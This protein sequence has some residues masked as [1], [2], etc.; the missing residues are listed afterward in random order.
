MENIVNQPIKTKRELALERMQTRY[1]DKDFSDDEALYGQIVE[2]FAY[3]DDEIAKYKERE[4]AFSDMFTADPRSAHFLTAW[5]K[6]EDP[7]VMLVRM[8]GTEIK[9][10][11]DDPDMLDQIS[12]AQKEYLE[13]VAKNK[14]YEAT[15]EG[16]M[17]E[18]LK[19]IEAVQTEMGLTDEKI[20]EA[21]AL[22]QGVVADGTL[23]KYSAESIK[24][25]LKALSHD[26][27]VAQAEHVGEVKGRNAK[28][29]EKLRVKKKGDGTL[30]LDGKNNIRTS[31][32]MPSL[33][34]IDRF[35][36]GESIWER[37][38]KK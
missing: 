11:I 19:N 3:G 36:E 28:I 25:A 1:P 26:A 13:R 4:K 8:F 21:M 38:K 15:Y 29:D 33:G 22:L 12:A 9:D 6:G 17:A 27:D 7:A 34:A 10:A 31:K 37:G 35:A 23:G 18:T 14:E 20:D 24:M 5:R 32:P 2:D 16:N 30:A